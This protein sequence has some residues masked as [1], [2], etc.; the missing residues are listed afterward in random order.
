MVRTFARAAV[1]A[2]AALLAVPL[3]AGPAAAT[4]P[5]PTPGARAG[6][7]VL[8]GALVAVYR[9]TDGR[10]V[11]RRLTDALHPAADAG[12]NLAGSPAVVPVGP[13]AVEIAGIGTDGA[14]WTRHGTFPDGW[15]WAPWTSRGGK[16]TGSP[17]L[18]CSVL[19]GPVVWVRGAD[20][21]LWRRS[22]N[23]PWTSLGGS[24]A[25]SPAAVSTTGGCPAQE[26]VVALGAD[27]AVWERRAGTWTRVGGRSDQA[28]ALVRLPDGRSYLYVVG[29]NKALYQ[30]LRFGDG[31]PWS[32]L[33]KK[34]TG[35]L[36]SAPAVADWTD[37][38]G[39]GPITVLATGGN[40]QL[41]RASSN[42]DGPWTFVPFG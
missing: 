13:D 28:P 3:L 21:A 26:D 20:G 34:G 2:A 36:T 23:G 37:A 32:P 10:V 4:D 30:A 12:G 16:A 38:A 17:A 1:V 33:R 22:F 35:V 27:K 31:L 42:D 6:T 18:G 25:S 14:V 19:D 11:L 5:P 8:N 40:G 29:T 39:G 7:G 24:L 41:Y 9:R 15:Q